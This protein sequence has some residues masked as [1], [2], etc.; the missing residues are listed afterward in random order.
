MNRIHRIIYNHVRGAFQVVSEHARGPSKCGTTRK[1]VMGA[2]LALT[3]TFASGTALAEDGIIDGNQTVNIVNESWT[4]DGT[5]YVGGSGEGTLIIGEDGVVESTDGDIGGY[6]S[7]SSSGTVRVEGA[8]AR[9]TN[10][11]SL[12]IG[13]FNGGTLTIGAGGVVQSATGTVASS[14]SADGT[15]VS[16]GIVTVE[17]QGAQWINSGLLVVG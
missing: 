14:R 8:G 17:G 7:E 11:N 13:G 1:A 15:G 5:L 4:V 2:M 6:W 9:W 12:R 16:T 3:L 10:A